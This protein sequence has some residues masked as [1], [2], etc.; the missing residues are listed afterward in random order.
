MMGKRMLLNVWLAVALLV[1]VWVVWQEPGHAPKPPAVK[2]TTLS[3]TVVN[4]LVITNHNGTITLN[5]QD[6]AWRLSQPV[7]I[8][9][10][11]VRVDDLLEVV[12]AKSLARFPAA[13]RDLKEYG[14]A[15]PAVRLR[16]NDT[17]ILFGGVTPVDQQRYV[18][19]GDTIHLIS[20]RYMFE[21]L[22][23]AAAWVSRDL[24]PPGKQIV[25]MQ[26]PDIKL[27]RNDKGEWSAAPSG[28][29]ESADA[30]QRVVEAWS[31]AQALRV[32]PY[33]KHPAQG[34]VVIG[35]AGEAQP[36]HY[37]IVARKPELILARP[38]IGMQFYVASEQADR[39]LSVK[40]AK[41]EA[42]A[43]KNN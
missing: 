5:K 2:L 34:E 9:A 32:T 42:A 24:V 41:P 6:G 35:I 14:L 27:A 15:K 7:A 37:R 30:V 40:A 22:G 26:L 13:G 12:Q 43:T 36:L 25:S 8:A 23:G 3:P 11:G 38:E 39:L 17:E 21:L 33:E 19:V 1:L 10:N 18:K 16:L 29:A 31:D 4:K 20:D 28:K